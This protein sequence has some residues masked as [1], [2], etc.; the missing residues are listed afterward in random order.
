MLKPRAG[1]ATIGS[2]ALRQLANHLALRT[3]V[4]Q[5]I[6]KVQH[7]YIQLIAHQRG[8]HAQQLL[9]IQGV[10]HLIIREC[11]IF[12]KTIDLCLDQWG[13]VEVLPLLAL[14]VHPQIGKQLLDLQRHQPGEDGITR[15]LR[16]SREDAIIKILIEGK[17]FSQ[18]VFHHSPLIQ[19]E[20]IDQDKKDLL[21]LIKQRENAL[22][23]KIRTHQRTILRMLNPINVIAFDKLGE[24]MIGLLFLH[25]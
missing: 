15:I 7:D 9:A 14:L 23:E 18:Q 3:S 2:F 17:V 25:P 22:L 21:L 19:A 10:V 20:V 5:H 6:H 12:A 8:N 16:S 4:R 1:Q 13:L 11:V 24:R